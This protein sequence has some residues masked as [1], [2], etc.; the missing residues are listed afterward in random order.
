MIISGTFAAYLGR[1]G[2][3]EP[4]S[5]SVEGLFALTRAHLERIPFENTEIQLG[6]PPGIDPELTVRRI[7]AGR[8]GYCFHLNGAFAALLEHLGYDVTRHVGGMCADADSREVSGDHLTLTVRIDGEAYFVD[9]GL[10]DGPPEP[11]P[12]REGRYERGFRY[13]LRPLGSADGPDTGWTFLNEDSPFPA[14][15]FR[16]APATMADF[17]AEHLR[18]STAEDSPFLQS[19]FM[20]RRD[21]GIMN[22]LH[23]RILLTLDPQGGRGKRDLASSEELFEV[24]TT[25]FGRELDDLTSADRAALW[26]RVQR[27][28][29]AWLAA[30]PS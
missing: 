27:A 20:L 12:L 29:E 26:D 8:G 11:L 17:E 16:S 2:I 6:R 18:L 9:V 30:Q 25:V 7:G 21:A 14:M 28:H 13:G 1:I 15:N 3:T 23:G 4:G 10:G 24:M 5:P 19:F 22:R